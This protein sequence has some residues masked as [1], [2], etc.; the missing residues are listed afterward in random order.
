MLRILC[1]ILICLA[2][3]VAVQGSNTGKPK[4]TTISWAIPLSLH[5]MLYA[6]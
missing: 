1:I 6:S 4:T 2:T 5:Q 3:A